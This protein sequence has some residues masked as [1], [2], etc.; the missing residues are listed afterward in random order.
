[1]NTRYNIWTRLL[2]T[3]VLIVSMGLVGCNNFLE[4]YSQDEVVPK[5]VREYSEILFGEAYLKENTL[6]YKYLDLLTDDVKAKVDLGRKSGIGSEDT[7]QEAYG[8]FTWQE[9]PERSPSGG[10]NSDQSWA[11]F[12]HHILT[13]NII[14]SEIDNMTG[15]KKE[16]AKLKGEAHAIKLNAYLM[17]ANLY[18]PAYDPA[19]AGTVL[20]VPINDKAHA[21]DTTFP[22]AT[23]EENYN[24]M[25]EELE[26]SVQA[27]QKSD[28][29]PSIFRWNPRAVS[30]I[31]S[32]MYLYKKDYQNAIKYATLAI[33][34]SPTLQNLNELDPTK[35]DFLRKSNP[36]IAYSYGVYSINFHSNGHYTY[37]TSSD[38]LLD[39]YEEGDL[40]SGKAGG[41][42]LKIEKVNIG[43]WIPK[44]VY[45]PNVFKGADKS[46]TYAYGFAIRNAEA[47][48]NR[49]EAYA[50]TGQLA[51]AMADINYLRQHRFIK[52]TPALDVPAT[53]QEVIQLVRDE[54]RREFPFEQLR[55]FDLRR[56]DQPEIT[57]FY[58]TNLETEEGEE[59]TLKAGDARY[60]LPIPYLVKNSDAAL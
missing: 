34:Q 42:F 55:W 10:L 19:T 24:L 44:Y 46:K 12:Y 52:G 11:T 5:D 53:Q 57:H 26:S 49:A 14:L 9:D 15:D 58:I 31:G 16:I 4:E 59:Y 22:R 35:D 50:E 33:S 3:S 23:L 56:W 39:M 40:R 38:E 29:T 36:E 32:R 17:L 45:Y 37:F 13:S 18:A 47:Y 41:Q 43:L 7:R 28:M 27:F 8:Y 1:M 21:E 30:I 48:L 60:T 2:V 6:P 25:I 51:K 20:G 54:R